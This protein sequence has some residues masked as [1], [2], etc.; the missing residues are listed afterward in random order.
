MSASWSA[1]PGT[2]RVVLLSGMACALVSWVAAAESE[3]EA[4]DFKNASAIERAL[5]VSS[6]RDIRVVEAGQA[7]GRVD[8]RVEF[9]FDSV[10]LTPSAKAQLNELGIALRSSALSNASF[11]VVGHTDAEGASD[12]NRRLSMRRAEAVQHYLMEQQGIDAA[13]LTPVGKG[14]DALLVSDDPSSHLN[15]R[16]EIITTSPGLPPRVTVDRAEAPGLGHQAPP[17]PSPERPRS[18]SPGAR[19]RA[20][21][22]GIGSYARPI[23][24]LRGPVQDAERMAS[25]LKTTLGY[26]ESE[27]TL[28]LEQHATR[29]NIRAALDAL[30]EQTGP[31]DQVVFYYSGHG[32]QQRDLDGDE[33]DGYDETLVP[34]DTRVD[35][36]GQIRNMI[37]DDEIAVT[38][39]RLEDRYAKVII[40]SCHSGTATRSFFSDGQASKTPFDLGDSREPFSKALVMA[41]RSETTFIEG[42]SRRAVWTA[43]SPWQKALVDFESHSGSVFTNLFL[44]GLRDRQADR[45]GDGVVTH[46]ELLD[47]LQVGSEAFCRRHAKRCQTGL[48][49]TLETAKGMLLEDAARFGPVNRDEARAGSTI[50]YLHKSLAHTNDVEVTLTLSPGRRLRLGDPLRIAVTSSIDGY[51]LLLDINSAGELTQL[52]P[53]RFSS[54][55]GHKIAAR[56]TLEVPGPEWG[57]ELQAFEPLGRGH[58]VALVVEDDVGL[59]ALVS[60]NKD[61]Q[62]IGDPQAYL[63]Q[64]SESLLEVWTNDLTNRR[65]RWSM[66][67]HSYEIVP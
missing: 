45:D 43:V 51:L 62:V 50:D 14:E 53:N 4:L 11:E 40:D 23:H 36:T 32:Y 37:S 30:V 61:L 10:R 27:V 12:Y 54:G 46:V 8:L 1:A 55:D 7:S 49:P 67:E 18:T 13:R 9:E 56:H 26:R 29:Q 2:A 52:F 38:F 48:T 24:S 6:T 16:V 5:A 57:F 66:V 17:P 65:V 35:A 33:D 42:D 44:S 22:V 19:R 39:S 59:T 64:V 41:H 20:L 28:L 25:F 63:G 60:Q 58:L 31:G 34:V 3:P 21:V 47:F 15:R